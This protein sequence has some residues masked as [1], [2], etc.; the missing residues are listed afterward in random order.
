MDRMKR[1]DLLPGAPT[2]DA[3]RGNRATLLGYRVIE[4]HGGKS[5]V[6][7][8]PT[9]ECANPVGQVHGGYLGL[10]VDDVC[11]MA[12]ASLLTEFRAFPTISM[13]IEFHRPIQIGETVECRGTVVRIGRRFIVIDTVVTGRDGKLRVRGT[14]TFVTDMEGVT[15]HDGEVLAGFTALDA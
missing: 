11:G 7:W 14:A 2:A 1:A 10:I 3:M 15:G 4:A 5:L 9:P 13:Q 12:F 8:T 6:E